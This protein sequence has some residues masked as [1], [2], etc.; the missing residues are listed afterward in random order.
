M[1]PGVNSRVHQ[2]GAVEQLAGGCR[3][4]EAADDD[5]T[6]VGGQPRPQG[7]RCTVGRLRAGLGICSAVEDIA[8]GDQ[9]GQHDDG[10][11]LRSGIGYGVGGEFAVGRRVA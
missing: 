2:R 11:A 3:F 4:A 6:V 1:L 9:F 5:D 7:Y 8:A 10:R